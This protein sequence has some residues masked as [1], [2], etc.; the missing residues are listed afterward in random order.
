MDG[1]RVFGRKHLHK[2]ERCLE[3]RRIAVGAGDP[4]VH[5]LPRHNGQGS[6]TSSERGLPHEPAREM[7]RSAVSFV[8]N[9]EKELAVHFK[10]NN[11]LFIS[12]NSTPN[13][14]IWVFFLLI[15]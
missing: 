1:T 8:R 6:L 9:R 15:K 2:Q 5:A 10:A 14:L 11:E 4:G 12:W 3:L 13:T 7:H